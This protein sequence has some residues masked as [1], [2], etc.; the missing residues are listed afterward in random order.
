[1]WERQWSDETWPPDLTSGPHAPN[2]RAEHR[3][4]PPINTPMLPLAESV[5]KVGFSPL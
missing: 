1:M 2:L 3:L 5:K 4:T